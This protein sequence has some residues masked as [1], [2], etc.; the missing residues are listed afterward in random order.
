MYV[1]SPVTQHLK[2]RFINGNEM[3]KEMKS[4][5]LL[6]VDLSFLISQLKRTCDVVLN[7]ELHG[8]GLISWGDR[9][10]ILSVDI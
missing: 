2:M 5:T 9:C 10:S 3:S 4:H 1:D 6:T 7:R 8:A